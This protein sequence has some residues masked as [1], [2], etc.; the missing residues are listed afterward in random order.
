MFKILLVSIFVLGTAATVGAQ[1]TD[2]TKVRDHQN[3]PTDIP[4]RD[5]ATGKPVKVPTQPGN[6]PVAQQDPLTGV[7]LHINPLYPADCAKADHR[8]VNQVTDLRKAAESETEVVFTFNTSLFACTA[9]QRQPL[10]V[11]PALVAVNVFRGGLLG[12]LK[13]K[14]VQVKYLAYADHTQVELT[15]DKVKSFKDNRTERDF[16]MGFYPWGVFGNYG[17]RTYFQ[18]HFPWRI[19]L[20]KLP[21][22]TATLSFM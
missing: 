20:V 17:G 3:Y 19:K 4:D 15:F 10:V 9:G 6:D 5:S 13:K 22:Q 18:A 8:S 14:L 12:G 11:N 16:S 21:D 7:Q 2:R 1:E